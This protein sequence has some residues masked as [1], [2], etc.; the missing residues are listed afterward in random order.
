MQ[1]DAEEK[2]R[3]GYACTSLEYAW[4]REIKNVAEWM[5]TDWHEARALKSANPWLFN[6]VAQC[7]RAEQEAE[8]LQLKTTQAEMEAEKSH[9]DAANHAY[10]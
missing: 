6:L 8:P 9:Q 7:H 2:A 4:A 5:K 3:S 1:V 10:Q